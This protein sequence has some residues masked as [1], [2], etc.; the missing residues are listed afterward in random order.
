MTIKPQAP[1]TG[2]RVV[3]FGQLIA[4]PL[5]G[6]VL[7]DYGAE[8]IK[9]EPLSGDAA[10]KLLSPW[11]QGLSRTEV[12]P[13]Y[14]AFNR[15]KRAIAL[16]L[17]APTGRAIASKL[18][19]TAD[20]VIQAFRPG[21]MDRLGLGPGQL[22]AKHPR[23][24]YA[25][26][27][28][29]GIDGPERNRAGLDLI[30]QAESGIMATTG[31]PGGPPTKV[32]FQVVDH[33]AG[34]VLAQGI[35]A[36]LIARERSGVGDHVH[37]SLLRVALNLQAAAFTE[38]L[39]SDLVP[40]R[41]GNAA[42]QSAPADVFAT[43]D[44][45]IVISAYTPGHWHKLCQ[46]LDAPDLENHPLYATVEARTAHRSELKADLEKSLSKRSTDEWLAL[47]VP[48]GLAAGRIKDYA[49][50][51]TDQARTIG[52]VY[53]EA[54]ANLR[55]LR[56]PVEFEAR[57]D[58]PLAEPP[59]LGRDSVAILME[60]GYTEREIEELISTHAIVAAGR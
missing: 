30:V 4:S 28:A 41:I 23:L 39:V 51:A 7:A 13:T 53:T 48:M 44:G 16:D 2:I 19:S 26:L 36:A 49:D 57:A 40:E 6:M 18:V 32:G 17:K 10:R 43:L 15:S 59:A 56:G 22:R 60:L 47:M 45:S 33:A 21:A 14:L 5:A 42:G 54:G 29:F 1:L 20:I 24:I 3:E 11:L 58:V 37:V 25:S 27:S 8:V 38:Y 50:I 12:S 46:L 34:Q 52:S 55:M 31:F 9:V 35:L